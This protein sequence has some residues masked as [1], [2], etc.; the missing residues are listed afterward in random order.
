MRPAAGA[1][2]RPVS[3][4]G[5]SD[6]L[7]ASYPMLRVNHSGELKG[8]DGACT[9]EAESWFSRLR[10]SEMGIHHQMSGKYLY[11]Y[12]KRWRGA[13]IAAGTLERPAARGRWNSFLRLVY[14]SEQCRQKVA[15]GAGA[16]AYPRFS[17]L[18]P[19]LDHSRFVDR[20]V[21]RDRH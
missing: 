2:L 19:A 18:S 4:A 6:A 13:R 5:A 16:S 1:L 10:R 7:H 17:N 8:D 15:H 12:V 9:N 14:R 21:A 11:Q 20:T 3:E